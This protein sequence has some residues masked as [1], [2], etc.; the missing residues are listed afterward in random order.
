MTMTAGKESSGASFV[1]VDFGGGDGFKAVGADSLAA[2]DF[3][4]APSGPEPVNGTSG[5][6][7]LTGSD[8]ADDVINGMNGH[9]TLYGL[10]GN[11]ALNG[12]AGNDHLYGGA[13]NDRLE[14]GDGHDKLLGEAGDDVLVGGAGNDWMDGGT[15][16]DIFVIAPGGGFDS[17]YRFETG[18]DKLDL[19]AFGFGDMA[20]LEEAAD[21]TRSLDGRSLWID[22]GG[23]DH[24]SV[25]GLD[26]D[27]I[28]AQ[29]V[30]F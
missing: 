13:G 1:T 25:F 19:S 23:G 10:S 29:N 30:I 21:V 16:A 17:I 15:G 9:D 18:S 20:G 8:N 26:V 14:G 24:V 3:L 4:F 27:K 6:D 7:K 11:D 28:S 2:G 5:N 22:F 12:G